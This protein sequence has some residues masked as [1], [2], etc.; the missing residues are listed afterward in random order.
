M[1]DYRAVD[2]GEILGPSPEQNS[3]SLE[4]CVSAG[5]RSPS[6]QSLAPLLVQ[7][8]HTKLRY[9]GGLKVTAAVEDG[10]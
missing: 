3:A 2:R 4:S 6:V 9:S 7:V 5:V 8:G 10:P 1:S